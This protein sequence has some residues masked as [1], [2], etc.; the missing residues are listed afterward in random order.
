MAA[1]GSSGAA[2]AT[3]TTGGADSTGG[4]DDT[5]PPQLPCN[6][7]VELCDR[8]FDQVVFPGTHNSHAALDDGFP[9]INANHQR[10]IAQQLDD[11]VRVMLLDIY[12]DPADDEQIVLC[13]GPCILASLPHLDG[14][15]TIVDFLRDNPREV[16][17][18]IYQDAV[19]VE[20]VAQDFA[21]TTADTLTYAHQPGTAWPTLGEMIEADTRLVITAESGG[22]PPAWYHHVWD[23]AWDTPYGPSS[24]DDLSCDHNRGSTDHDLFLMNHWVNT[25]VGLPDQG[26]AS[27]VNS[28]DVL[29]TRAQECW[30]RWDHPPN[31]VVVDWYEQ[32]DLFAVV[33]T[34]NGI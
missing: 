20:E 12:P 23:E 5:S 25:L 14:L 9:I 2:E 11:G 24:I 18:I 27:E 16:L 15:Q 8:S 26:G 29:L 7:H 3:G 31:F 34:L 32:G 33:D 21:L 6:G 28:T 4:S 30:E 13:H 19:D 10:G 1:A 22:P 17:T